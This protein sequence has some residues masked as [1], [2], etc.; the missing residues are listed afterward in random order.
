VPQDP[1][2]APCRHCDLMSR[3]P[4]RSSGHKTV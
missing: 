2:T 1:F 3:E 4:G